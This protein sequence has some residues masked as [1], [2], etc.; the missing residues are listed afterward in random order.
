MMPRRTPDTPAAAAEGLAHVEPRAQDRATAAEPS[1]DDPAVLTVDE[2]AALLRVN[3]KTV[4]ELIARGEIP[5][6]RRLGRV[7]R[8][9]RPTVL[10]WL[11][12]G[13]GRAPRSRS[14]R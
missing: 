5:G 1:Q 2:T 4:Y 7:V 14:S 6:V 11:A 10:S 9:H 8:I 13:Q 12:E 3:R